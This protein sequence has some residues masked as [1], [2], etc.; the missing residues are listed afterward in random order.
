MARL[1]VV[2]LL[3]LTLT[4]APA[5]DAQ[6]PDRGGT[7]FAGWFDAFNGALDWLFAWVPNSAPRKH[8]AFIDPIGVTA[9][10]PILGEPRD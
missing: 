2:L 4:L 8:G 7:P 3:L 9:P 6:A 10:P 1:V 5:A